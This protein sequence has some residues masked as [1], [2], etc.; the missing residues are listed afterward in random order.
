MSALS[1]YSMLSDNSYSTLSIS[2]SNI[3]TLD[4]SRL[5]LIPNDETPEMLLQVMQYDIDYG[6]NTVIDPLTVIL[7]ISDNEITDPRIE[8]AINE[9][10]ENCLHD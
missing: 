8:S 3:M 2:K 6:D 4:T 7:S 1:Y 5:P 10:L 9:V